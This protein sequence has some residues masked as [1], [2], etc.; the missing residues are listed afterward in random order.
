MSEILLHDYLPHH[1]N[2]S[3]NISMM[4]IQTVICSSGCLKEV[5]KSD[6]TDISDIIGTYLLFKI[7]K[8]L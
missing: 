3:R 7:Y 5:I 2:T 1:F 8:E 6:K 4:I